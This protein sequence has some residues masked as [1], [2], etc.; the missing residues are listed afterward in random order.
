MTANEL[1]S[2]IVEVCEQ[3][4]VKP[5]EAIIGLTQMLGYVMAELVTRGIDQ[6]ELTK[7]V[8]SSVASYFNRFLNQ[9]R[10][11]GA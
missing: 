1:S 3:N 7:G 4:E 9:M 11:P 6:P 10:V 8:A 5:R 2:K